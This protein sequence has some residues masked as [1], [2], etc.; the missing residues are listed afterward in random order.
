MS[1]SP[2]PSGPPA[3]GNR[4]TRTDSQS[5]DLPGGGKPPIPAETPISNRRLRDAKP[6]L[7]NEELVAEVAALTRLHELAMDLAGPVEPR[8]RFTTSF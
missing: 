2:G 8:A 6:S 5:L 7:S 1:Y 3:Q 4:P